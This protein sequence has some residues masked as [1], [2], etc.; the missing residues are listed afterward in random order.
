M[1]SYNEVIVF[2]S[3][4]A[5]TGGGEEPIEILSCSSRTRVHGR[6]GL[7]GEGSGRAAAA[8]RQG[9]RLLCFGSKVQRRAARGSLPAL[10]DAS[11]PGSSKQELQNIFTVLQATY[12]WLQSC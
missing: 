1:K 2:K 8:G 9:A 11:S 3:S 4:P 6:E 5:W 12:V 7:D 10:I